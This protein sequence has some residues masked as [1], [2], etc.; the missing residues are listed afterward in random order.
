MSACVHAE[1]CGYMHVCVCVLVY[2]HVCV[3]GRKS[4]LVCA[5]VRVCVFVV[6][7]LLDN[8]HVIV[9]VGFDALFRLLFDAC[10]SP[11]S[12]R[13]REHTQAQNQNA[14]GKRKY[15]NTYPQRI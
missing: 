3:S 10:H 2:V 13:T 4:A 6:V 8:L 9:E 11:T 12:E 1:L 15:T 5:Y 14:F 7:H